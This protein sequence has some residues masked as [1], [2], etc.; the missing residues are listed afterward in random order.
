M[1]RLAFSP[2]P[3]D[4][5]IFEPIVHKRIDLEGLSFEYRM[6]DVETL[7]QIAL[8]GNADMIKVSYH[9]YLYLL[10]NFVLLQSGSALGKGNGPLLIAKKHIPPDEIP[11]LT[12]AVPGEFTTAHLLFR[13]AFPQSK[14]KRFMVFSQIEEE[15][16]N[17][18]VDAGV[19]IHEN[20]FTYQDKGLVKLLDL[21]EFWEEMTHMPIPLGGIVAR[22]SLGYDVINKLNRIMH[23]SVQYSMHHR[24]EV[25]PFVRANAKEMSEDVM[26]KHINLFVNDFTLQLGQEGTSAISTL[27]TTARDKKLIP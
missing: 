19:I 3:N 22:K 16:L 4:T 2:C 21:G 5:C 27:I 17:G 20:R 14:L 23:R 26:L 7:N 24:Q 8:K 15:I 25:M 10:H 9:A 1:I 11:F 13:L 12:I 6:E 18:K